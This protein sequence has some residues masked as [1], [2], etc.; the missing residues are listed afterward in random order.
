MR[1]LVLGASGMLGHTVVRTLAAGGNMHQVVAA[2][3]SLDLRAR[4]PELS[5]IESIIGVD[6]ENNDALLDTF[7]RARPDCVI[8]CIGLVKQ[9]GDANDP[10][11]ILPINA[12]LPHRLA[13]LCTMIGARLI[14][15]STDCVF[16]GTRGNY[17][18]DDISDA[19]DL[20]GKSKYL[21]E[22][23]GPNAITL[24][25]SIVGHELRGSQGLIEWFLSQKGAIRGYRNA[26][27]SGL[28]TVELARVIRDYVLPRKELNGLFHVAAAPISKFDLLSLVAEIYGKSLVIEPDDTICINRSLDGSRFESATGYVAPE[29][30][31][32]ISLMHTDVCV[33]R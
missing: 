25:T 20:Y 24:R 12:M 26:I 19:T 22:V 27:F 14:H 11:V 29:W 16:Q 9:R 10:L 5:E 8:N 21:G 28:P 7:V 17:T 15:I 3:R 23:Q 18:E 33:K 2:S 13:Y 31:E 30:Y 4:F 6:A 1:I 32:L